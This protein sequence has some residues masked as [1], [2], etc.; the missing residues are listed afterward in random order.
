[1]KVRILWAIIM[2]GTVV[3]FILYANDIVF[4]I[5][6]GL[7]SLIAITELM[8][9]IKKPPAITILFLYGFVIF[10]TW[11]SYQYG[12]LDSH[13][14]IILFVV[15]TVLLVLKQ[16]LQR[17]DFNQASIVYMVT[18]YVVIS[19]NALIYIKVNYDLYLFFYPVIIA[20]LADTFGY[21][22]GKLLGKNK[23]IPNISP[24]KTIEGAVFA[25]ISATTF[26]IIYLLKLGY[27]IKTT[28]IITTLM[29]ILSQVGDLVASTIKRTYEIK[30]YSNMI[31]GHGGIM[32]R[33]DSMLYNYIILSIILIYI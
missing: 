18:L 20:V 12:M 17:Y 13:Y 15:I 32:D 11:F 7:I 30:D 3:P 1:M 5:G 10:T 4:T 9:A 26:S 27:E 24:N 19:F 6:V 23:L 21:F 2:I 14:Y 33:M 16:N 22:G 8:N 28:I 29:V 31:P 25:T